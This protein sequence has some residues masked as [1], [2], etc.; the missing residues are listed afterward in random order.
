MAA[1][2]AFHIPKTLSPTGAAPSPR[3]DTRVALAEAATRR[4]R[5]WH[6]TGV[7][8]SAVLSG[9]LPRLD[10]ALPGSRRR[11]QLA[12]RP[13]SGMALQAL[14]AAIPNLVGGPR[15]WEAAPGPL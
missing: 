5:L 4:T 11:G 6:P 12:T 2:A 15:T 13:A 8:S 9:S 3:A 10:N 14:A 7:L 1:G